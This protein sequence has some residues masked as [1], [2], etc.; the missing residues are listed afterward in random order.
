MDVQGRWN[1][2]NIRAFFPE[3]T[4]E[5][6]LQ[7]QIS[8]HGGEDLVYW[9]HTRFG[10]YTVRS[11]YNLDRSSD[12]F[13]SHSKT[14][15]GLPSSREVEEKY[16]K[17]IWVIKATNKM[18]IVLWRFAHNCIPSGLQ[19]RHPN[20]P[21]NPA[22]VHCGRDESIEHCLLFCQFASE[23]W[24]KVKN[25]S[26]STYVARTSTKRNSNYLI[27]LIEHHRSSPLFWQSLY[28]IF[29]KQGMR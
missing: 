16:W 14:G 17:A 29:G 11:A 15:R 12:F 18:N 22:C 19:L 10:L 23:V 27:S 8:S 13:L 1:K 2:E 4:A 21:T 28:G 6:I 7:T 5:L 9:P 24:N 20:I 25:G 3:E 26:T